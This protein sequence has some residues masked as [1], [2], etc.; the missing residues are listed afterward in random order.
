[1]T[2]TREMSLTLTP[3]AADAFKKIREEQGFPPETG[4]RVGIKGGGCSGFEY[5]L[6]TCTRAAHDD[7]VFESHGIRL[8]IDQKSF[9]YLMGSTIGFESTL[10]KRGFTFTNPNASGTCGCGTSFSV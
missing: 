7:R 6:D 1:M 9:L 5:Y 3:Q 8:F 10:A 2:E 4:L